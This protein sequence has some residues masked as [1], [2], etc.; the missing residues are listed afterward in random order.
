MKDHLQNRSA[1]PQPMAATATTLILGPEL[2]WHDDPSRVIGRRTT[3]HGDEQPYLRG[4]EVVV[5]AVI[6]DPIRFGGYGYVTTEEDLLCLGGVGPDD[7][8]EVSPIL[9]GA[10]R[11]SFAT[12]DP[13]AIDLEI[14]RHLARG[15]TNTSTNR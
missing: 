9:P 7:R 2:E 6:K 13:R 12:S 3:Y 8:I 5:I 11:L 1:D 4:Y 15:G 14:F 10:G